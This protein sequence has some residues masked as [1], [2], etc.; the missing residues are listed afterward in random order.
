MDEYEYVPHETVT[1]SSTSMDREALALLGL[2]ALALGVIW[3]LAR[4]RNDAPSPAAQQRVA[5]LRPGQRA[6]GQ[7][8]VPPMEQSMGYYLPE[9]E[10]DPP[11]MDPRQDRFFR[12]GDEFMENATM[13]HVIQNKLL[14][15]PFAPA[16]AFVPVTLRDQLAGIRLDMLNGTP[17]GITNGYVRPNGTVG[18][19]AQSVPAYVGSTASFLTQPYTVLM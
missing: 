11:M 13:R 12:L 4:G 6:D 17:A 16:L 1:Q 2:G 15:D 10:E 9:P 19:L 8:V 5:P 7:F 18:G 14:E 3:F